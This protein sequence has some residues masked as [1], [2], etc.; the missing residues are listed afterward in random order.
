MCLI[1]FYGTW[2]PMQNKTKM[3]KYLITHEANSVLKLLEK[4]KQVRSRIKSNIK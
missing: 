1:L 4:A 3:F 2:Y